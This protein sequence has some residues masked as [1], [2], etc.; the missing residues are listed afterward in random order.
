MVADDRPYIGKGHP[1]DKRTSPLVSPT[2]RNQRRP[3]LHPPRSGSGSLHPRDQDGRGA[4][5]PHVLPL[6]DSGDA[7]G[8]LYCVRPHV[9]G[10]S[11]RQRIAREGRLPVDEAIRLV[12]YHVPGAAR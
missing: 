2:V 10:E 1:E 4:Q 11:L 9:A 3:C 8:F 6:H 5:P 7:G 12:R